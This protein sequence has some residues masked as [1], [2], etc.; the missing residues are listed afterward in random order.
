MGSTG[1]PAHLVTA[2]HVHVQ[3]GDAVEGM[4]ADIE[5]EAVPACRDAL[6]AGHRLGGGEAGAR[7]VARAALYIKRHACTR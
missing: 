1:R 2:H 5:Y 3:V 4:L 6:G 7:P